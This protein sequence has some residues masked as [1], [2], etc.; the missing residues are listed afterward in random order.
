M[1]LQ[2]LMFRRNR[3]F[4]VLQDQV[5][6]SSDFLVLFRSYRVIVIIYFL[7]TLQEQNFEF[8]QAPFICFLLRIR[9]QI[10]QKMRHH[11][12]SSGG[13]VAQQKIS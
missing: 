4:H 7:Q 11:F 13:R 10:A 8:S 6:L 2:T 1:A 5:S 9:M 12:I 3:V